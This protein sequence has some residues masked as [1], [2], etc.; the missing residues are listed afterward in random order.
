VASLER[1]NCIHEVYRLFYDVYPVSCCE[2]WIDAVEAFSA[3]KDISSSVH[4]KSTSVTGTYMTFSVALSARRV[5]HVLVTT[6]Q[7]KLRSIYTYI[8]CVVLLTHYSVVG[9]RKNWEGKRSLI[10]TG[11]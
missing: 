4:N 2:V 10:E 9:C 8:K 1:L 3:M 7:V 6:C 5:H 11:A